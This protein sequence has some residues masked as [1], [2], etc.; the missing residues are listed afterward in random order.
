[1]PSIG[2]QENN[3]L[4]PHFLETLFSLLFCGVYLANGSTFR[5]LTQQGMLAQRGEP[6]LWLLQYLVKYQLLPYIKLNCV[7]N[8]SPVLKALQGLFHIILITLSK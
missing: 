3:Q 7:L 5:S 6:W 8:P 1:M 2:I 4:R